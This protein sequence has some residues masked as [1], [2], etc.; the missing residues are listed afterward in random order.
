MGGMDVVLPSIEGVMDSAGSRPGYL[1]P[2]SSNPDL[3]RMLF[4]DDPS[5]EVKGKGKGKADE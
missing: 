4:G 5:P 1:S 2:L 3:A